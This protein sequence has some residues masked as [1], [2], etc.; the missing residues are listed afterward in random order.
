MRQSDRA[1]PHAVSAPAVA[2]LRR[3]AVRDDGLPDSGQSGG[4]SGNSSGH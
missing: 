1:R 4:D 2:A 3:T